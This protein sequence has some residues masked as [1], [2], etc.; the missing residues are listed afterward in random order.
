[1]PGLIAT[2]S[3]QSIGLAIDN[4]LLIAEYMP[5]DELRNQ[6]VVLLPLQ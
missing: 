4:I 6:V 3:K 1:M 5:E 2:T